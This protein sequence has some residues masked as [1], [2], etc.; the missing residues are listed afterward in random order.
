MDDLQ[1]NERT[2]DFMDESVFNIRSRCTQKENPKPA[3]SKQIA[4]I[5]QRDEDIINYIINEMK[6]TLG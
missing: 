4:V 3:I 2:I 1:Y 5:P 6:D